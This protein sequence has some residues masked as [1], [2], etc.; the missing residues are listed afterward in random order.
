[1]KSNILSP[2]FVLHKD[3]QYALRV[4]KPVVAL[5]TA[6]LTHGLPYPHN[7]RYEC[8]LCGWYPA[9]FCILQVHVMIGS[10]IQLK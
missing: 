5:E 6:I 3:V 4:Q 1:M 10:P 7:I 2:C 8:N 9:V